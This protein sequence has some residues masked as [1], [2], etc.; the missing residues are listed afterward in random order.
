MKTYVFLHSDG[1]KGGRNEEGAMEFSLTV[2]FP[3]RAS[4]RWLG[5]WMISWTEFGWY[6]AQEELRKVVSFVAA[7]D[8]DTRS[9]RRLR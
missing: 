7:G 4:R 8:V 1:L 6:Q 2:S 9:V 5:S 3:Q